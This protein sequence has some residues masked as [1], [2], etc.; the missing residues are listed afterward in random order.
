M[1]CFSPSKAGAA[2]CL[3]VSFS[4]SACSPL[5]GDKTADHTF[6]QSQLSG[7]DWFQG[8]TRY[9]IED[10]RTLN[11]LQPLKT[12]DGLLQSIAVIG[13]NE[14]ASTLYE[15]SFLYTTIREILLQHNSPHAKTPPR[16]DITG[17]TW[18]SVL[19]SFAVVEEEDEWFA[20][21][22]A[23]ISLGYLSA[24]AEVHIQKDIEPACRRAF[25]FYREND[26]L[27]RAITNTL[28]ACEKYITAEDHEF[29]TSWLQAHREDDSLAAKVEIWQRQL[30]L[31]I[32][33]QPPISTESCKDTEATGVDFSSI[34]ALLVLHSE[35][36]TKLEGS[37]I[38]SCQNIVTQA[39]LEPLSGDEQRDYFVA[40]SANY[41]QSIGTLETNGWI[42]ALPAVPE[43]SNLV[44]AYVESYGNLPATT[45]VINHLGPSNAEIAS[46]E[47]ANAFT[48]AASNQEY[49]P[50][51]RVQAAS[52][53]INLGANQDDV[54]NL[55]IDIPRSP[56]IAQ[57]NHLSDL[58]DI[59]LAYNGYGQP[60]P[61]S[62]SLGETP[63]LESELVTFGASD[64]SFEINSPLHFGVILTSTT[65]DSGNDEWLSALRSRVEEFLSQPSPNVPT[66]VLLYSALVYPDPTTAGEQVTQNI[67]EILSS[68][69]NCASQAPFPP[70]SAINS[71]CDPIAVRYADLLKKRG[72]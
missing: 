47:M 52:A 35:S 64:D 13:Q 31:G 1:Y 16:Y 29:F 72:F 40:K 46:A 22:Q 54:A 38:A 11:A 45:I 58:A 49:P 20:E 39:L 37:D 32:P 55:I 33:Y 50:A 43:S 2:F 63:P 15:P 24:E 61:E 57:N 10:A 28:T 5:S 21:R 14:R 71:T 8:G 25:V 7:D 65:H 68:R 9:P 59:M 34:W 62:F 51:E 60:P 30:Q 23:I 26:K 56:G 4:V 27:T 6:P 48:E 44:A 69:G 42:Q 53:L 67:R 19:E 18:D 41:V 17:Q 3:A 70:L 12:Q 66:Q 36:G